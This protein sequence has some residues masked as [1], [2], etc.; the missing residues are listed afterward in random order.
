MF[1]FSIY[2]WLKA[3]FRKLLRCGC[4]PGNF[5]IILGQLCLQKSILQGGYSELSFTQLFL[6][7]TATI[8]SCAHSEKQ[9][10]F[11]RSLIYKNYCKSYSKLI[12][13]HILLKWNYAVHFCFLKTVKLWGNK[14]L[15]WGSEERCETEWQKAKLWELRYCIK[16][17][18]FQL[19]KEILFWEA[20]YVFYTNTV[21]FS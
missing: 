8:F 17:R 1:S 4:F 6:F 19:R 21:R 2:P 7:I 18:L 14:R 15:L 3:I 12:I 16:T 11:Y 20:V 9:E 10:D 13:C 5:Y